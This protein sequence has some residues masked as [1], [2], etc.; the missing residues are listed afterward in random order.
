MPKQPIRP[1]STSITFI[2]PA[3]PPQ[4]PVT[5]PNIS[6]IS[7]CGGTPWAIEWPWPR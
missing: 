2:E 4:A 1:F 6:S 3:R 7:F 5:R